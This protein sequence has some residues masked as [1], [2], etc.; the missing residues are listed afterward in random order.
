MSIVVA[1]KK[2]SQIALACDSLW[3]FG[4]HLEDQ[5]NVTDKRKFFEVGS[6]LLA[7]TGWGLYRNI[8]AHYLRTR[9]TPPRLTNE[10]QVFEFFLRFLKELRKNYS[11]VNEQSRTE[12]TPFA[13]LDSDFLVLNRKGIYGVSTDLSV[14]SYERYHAIGSGCDYAFGALHTIY[15]E[16]KSAAQIAEIAVSAATHFDAHC[17]GKI[18]VQKVK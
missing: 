8:F 9:R 17:G 10:Q 12:E 18:V 1:V 5:T 7:F 4:S 15:D 11:F 2:G 3:I 6:A 14:T 16:K 13:D